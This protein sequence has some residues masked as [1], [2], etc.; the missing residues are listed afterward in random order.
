MHG[1]ADFGA[2][3][4]SADLLAQVSGEYF[5]GQNSVALHTGYCS[6]DGT[7]EMGYQDELRVVS[8]SLP[9]GDVA[10]L[11]MRVRYYSP[12]SYTHLTLPTSDLV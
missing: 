6:A 4:Y 5:T 1:H 3:S 11:R 9:V 12:V 10:T 8:S 7:L 2:I